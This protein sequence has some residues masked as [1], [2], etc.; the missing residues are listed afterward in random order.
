MPGNFIPPL[1][2]M[3]CGAEPAFDPYEPA[4][5]PQAYDDALRETGAELR[6]WHGRDEDGSPRVVGLDKAGMVYAG[7]GVLTKVVPCRC[8][9]HLPGGTIKGSPA[10]ADCAARARAKAAGDKPG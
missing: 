5:D 3:R 9:E 10:A 2:S 4:F 7:A 6:A 1:E 8:G